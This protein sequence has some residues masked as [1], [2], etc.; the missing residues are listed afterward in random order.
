MNPYDMLE[1]FEAQ[2]GDYNQLLN[3][4][5]DEVHVTHPDETKARRA[6]ALL[7]RH[8]ELI[9][10]CTGY[11]MAQPRIVALEAET[12][13]LKQKLSGR[14]PGVP[15]SHS[16]KHAKSFD[17]VPLESWVEATH[18]TRDGQYRLFRHRDNV[19]DVAYMRPNGSIGQID[20]DVP[21]AYV[22]AEFI[23]KGA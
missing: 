10:A 23:L 2:H 18:K 1:R 20:H 17:D 5:V 12:A 7:N 13:D 4:Y 8:N 15:L 21:R 19:Y 3:N 22:M 9:W 16:E 14:P 6:R 11:S